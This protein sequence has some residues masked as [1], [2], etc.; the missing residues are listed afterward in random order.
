M[1]GRQQPPAPDDVP[2]SADDAS[3]DD[4]RAPKGRPT[5]SRKEAEA[6]RKQQLKIPKDPRAAKKAARERD[7]SERAKARAAMM[8]GDDRYLPPRDQGPAKA[9]TRDFVDSRFTIAEFFIFVAIAVL[10]LG[11]VQNPAMQSFVSLAFFAFT[12]LIVIDTTILLVTLNRRAAK[13]F[14]DKA[15]RKGITLYALLRA[16]QLRRLRI[17]PPKVKRGGAPI[18]R[19]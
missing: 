3:L 2:S 5:P 15:D 4:P 6:A 12:A 18:E 1:F 13:Q 8:A 9:F 10:V 19:R 16:L 17:P 7:R 11:F 14:P